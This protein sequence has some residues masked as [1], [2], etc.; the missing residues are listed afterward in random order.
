MTFAPF[1][2]AFGATLLACCGGAAALVASTGAD[3]PA[4]HLSGSVS[5][6][7]KAGWLRVALGQGKCDVL[8]AGSSMALNN[9]AAGRLAG[10]GQS[11]INIG[12]FGVSP[13]DTLELLR[14]VTARCAPKL[15]VMPV[16]QGDFA[17]TMRQTACQALTGRSSI[18]ASRT[19]WRSS[20][21]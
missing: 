11:V 18:P 8:V 14:I 16:Y 6:N 17:T 2:K 5:F 7:E 1:L 4:P 19:G 12:S 3:L 13:E 21:R 9:V 15:I 10:E 20:S